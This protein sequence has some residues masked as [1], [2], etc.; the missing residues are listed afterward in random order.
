MGQLYY[1]HQIISV[2]ETKY[3]LG[4]DL[5]KKDF[6]ACMVVTDHEQDIKVKASRTFPNTTSGFGQLWEWAGKNRKEEIPFSIVMEATGVYHENIAWFLH[7]KEVDVS[8]M[9]PNRTKAYMT[10]L[11]HKSKNDQVDAKGLAMMGAVQKLPLW[12]PIS[13][14]IYQLRALTRHLED[15]QNMRTRL[16]NQQEQV[17]YAMY[18]VPD[19]EKSLEKTLKAVDKQVDACRKKVRQ[20]LHN[21]K[22]L[23]A[24]VDSMTSIKGVSDM[25][26][27]VVIA[28]TNGFALIRNLKQLASYA[29]YDVKENQSGQKTG[30]TKITK[31]GNAHIRRAMHLPAFNTVRYKVKPFSNLYE[32]VYDRSEIKMKAYVA[33]QSKLL[34]MMYTLWKTQSEFDEHYQES[35]ESR[36]QEAKLPLSVISGGNEK[37]VAPEGSEATLGGNPSDRSAEVPLSVSQI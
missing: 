25:T 35:V 26:V 6:K 24:K 8:I 30:K 5:S 22:E 4:L 3:C 18:S 31:K 34:G 1:S 36:D 33:V 32:R 11:G 10:S 29:G 19:V 17:K 13:K 27:A 16:L 28:E 7:K 9:L 20:V 15:L 14:D 2:M 37:K 21:E 12:K 23:S